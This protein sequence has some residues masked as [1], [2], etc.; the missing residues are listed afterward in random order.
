MVCSI[1]RRPAKPSRAPGSAMITSGSVAKDA[2]TPPYVGSVISEMVRMP[3]WSSWPS[4]WLVLAICISAMMPSC[5]RAPPD[6]VTRISGVRSASAISAAC[7]IASPTALP[8][9]P[10]RNRKSMIASTA[11]WP[12]IEPRAQSTASAR[13]VLA[14]A[15]RSR[16]G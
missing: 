13:P 6:A 5:I 3:A 16:A 14:R 2:A 15:S 10:P 12:P 1:T 7:V 8:R 9:L 4:A 11:W